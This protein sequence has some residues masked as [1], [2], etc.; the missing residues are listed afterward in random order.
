[1]YL[2]PFPLPL[3]AS[4]LSKWKQL[5]EESKIL[6]DSSYSM[7]LLTESDEVRKLNFLK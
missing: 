6:Y 7:E 5:C 4:L 2:G 3:R 1:M